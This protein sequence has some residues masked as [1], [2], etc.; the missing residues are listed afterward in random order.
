MLQI[1]QKMLDDVTPYALAR[2]I[3]AAVLALAFL[4]RVFL[5]QV[6]FL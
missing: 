3:F 4:A 5:L 6:R 1:Y 2:W